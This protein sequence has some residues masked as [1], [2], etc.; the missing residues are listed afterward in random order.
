MPKKKT[1]YKA[2]PFDPPKLTDLPDGSGGTK[3]AEIFYDLEK[4]QNLL[5]QCNLCHE[6][7]A[8]PNG[9]SCQ[10]FNN[11]RG[12]RGCEEARELQKIQDEEKKA[13]IDCGS[14]EEGSQVSE[15][16]YTC[17]NSATK[18]ANLR[19]LTFTPSSYFNTIHSNQRG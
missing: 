9:T 3:K 17:C 13:L 1:Q 16:Q 15:F 19:S 14:L 11:H 6:F 18:H 7:V 12:G 10:Q 4:P 8:F 5:L 2:A